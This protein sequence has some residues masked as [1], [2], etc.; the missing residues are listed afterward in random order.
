MDA[1][2]TELLAEMGHDVDLSNHLNEKLSPTE[3]SESE[4]KDSA[5]DSAD[6]RA[7]RLKKAGIVEPDADQLKRD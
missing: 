6:D 5:D 3:A 4:D 1:A 2:V 7:D